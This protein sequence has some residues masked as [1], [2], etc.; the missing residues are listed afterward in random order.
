[1]NVVTYSRAA[2][3]LLII[4][5]LTV[6]A[7]QSNN[8]ELAIAFNKF[9]LNNGLTVVV[10]EDHKA[11]IVSVSV[12][13]HVGSKD[14]RPGKTGFAHLFEHLMFNGTEHYNDEYFGPLEKAGATGMNGTTNEDRTNYY[15]TVPSS[16]LD[17]AL[18][19][20]SDRMGHMI[21]AITQARLDEQ[22]GV[23]QNEKRQ[24][25]NQPY[26]L[27][28]S[29]VGEN[30][31]PEGH[32]YS[33]SVIGSMDDLNA[34]TLNDVHQ[35]FK[36]YY[37]AANATLVL[38][39]DITLET[40][41][42]KAEYYFG[43]IPGGEPLLRQKSWI[44]KRSGTHRSV[45]HDQVPHARLIK[46]W[47]TA[48]IGSFDAEM[49]DVLTSILAGGKNS[50]L[51]KRLVHEDQI[52]T[53]VQAFY[54]G[55]EIA[56]QVWVMADAK[57]DIPLAT[58]ETAIDEELEKL[59]Q[60]GPSKKELA[61]V[62][63]STY[64][65][66]VHAL[67][68]VAG[69]AQFLANGQ[70]YFNQPDAYLKQLKIIE[71]A[72]AKGI[73]EIGKRWLS[74]GSYVLE[75]LPF[76]QHIAGKPQA[77]REQLPKLG[78]PP[79]FTLP[80][81]KHFTLKNG[82]KVML[83]ER[84]QVPIVEF[85]MQFDAGYAADQHHTL[86]TA[87]FTMAMLKEA[88]KSRSTFEISEAEEMLGASISTGSTLDTS[89]VGLS[90]L[91]KNL[92]PSLELYADIILH[93]AFTED[94]INRIKPLI[95]A[96]IDKEK[97]KPLSMALRTLPP[98]LY[99]PDHAYGIPFTGKGTNQSV[100]TIAK[101]ELENFHQ[102]WFRPDNATLII[103]G[104]TTEK[105]ITPLLEKTFSGWKKPADKLPAKQLNTVK[106]K[107]KPEFYLID[108]PGAIQGTLIAGHIAPAGNVEND[109]AI[110]VANTIFGGSFT[111]RLNLNL[112]EDKHWSYGAGSVLSAAKG[113]R[114][115]FTY[116]S[117]QI[118]KTADAIAEILKEFD[119]YLTDKPATK[120]ELNKV[121]ANKT[122]KLPGQYET[123]TAL[124]NGLSS[125][126]RFNRPDDYLMTWGDKVKALEL[127]EIRKTAKD[128]F[129][130]DKLTWIIVG[131]RK[132]IEPQLKKLKLKSIQ[133]LDRDGQAT[134]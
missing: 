76:P 47:N 20:E 102:T 94:D 99:G 68:T 82:L 100:A 39:G 21:G 10:H 67:E 62:K 43:H 27:A 18:W 101:K 114:P 103:V 116:T 15:Q 118:D 115:F 2:L 46:V 31:F 92:T 26:G 72:N 107:E 96:S 131:D 85:E 117:V 29:T 122:L 59:L 61:R 87:Y 63:T 113:Q 28:W 65:G 73:K 127:S 93:P 91:K 121:K 78:K 134:Q 90:S 123:L 4:F 110:D 105:E 81:I 112:R 3:L 25:E 36:N 35:W 55:R 9:K 40:A 42:Q 58:L 22:R 120:D 89:N 34:A 104:D 126:A 37:G 132:L 30:T 50:R 133:F 69:K 88:T 41:K 32:P 98:L 86:G 11:P 44:A 125:L 106:L 16:A 111:S 109:I 97:S 64:A 19:M 56:G 130:P 95:L 129:H 71:N 12:W 38:A 33:W 8:T 80:E 7:K 128:V 83:A 14:E 51:Y 6:V 13:Y 124:A 52:A 5:P 70:V 108:Q 17:L 66:M 49:L 24:R 45:M 74:D 75:I 48:E 84:H 53:S 79:A 119:L 1:M 77:N 23:V 54:Y 57:K 60:K